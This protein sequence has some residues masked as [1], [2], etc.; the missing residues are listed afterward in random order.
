MFGYTYFGLNKKCNLGESVVLF[1]VIRFVVVFV[2]V[3]GTRPYRIVKDLEM[4]R[5][6]AIFGAWEYLKGDN[7]AEISGCNSC[8]VN[9]VTWCVLSAHSGIV[10][11]HIIQWF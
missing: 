8:V 7:G 5:L 4:K 10:V 11:C 9:L 1:L 6:D 2:V 3:V